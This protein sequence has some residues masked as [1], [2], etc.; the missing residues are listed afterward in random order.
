MYL[1]QLSEA[2]RITNKKTDE[3]ILK[4]KNNVCKYDRGEQSTR[5]EML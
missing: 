1:Q 2:K 4:T 3:K 5:E